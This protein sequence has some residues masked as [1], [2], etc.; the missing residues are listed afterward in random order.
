M[1]VSCA[2]YQGTVP[3][4]LNGMRSIASTTPTVA[5]QWPPT[6]QIYVTII[7][8]CHTNLAGFALAL[9]RTSFTMGRYFMAS[10]SVQYYWG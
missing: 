7:M 6:F 1:N 3:V 4:D 10:F 5:T 2:A 8:P 9:T